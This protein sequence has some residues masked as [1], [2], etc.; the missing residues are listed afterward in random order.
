MEIAIIFTWRYQV[1]NSLELAEVE[2]HG[3]GR[4][5]GDEDPDF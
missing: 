3:W 1:S 4:V 5:C 2:V